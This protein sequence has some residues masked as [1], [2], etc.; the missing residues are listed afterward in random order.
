[1]ARRRFNGEGIIPTYALD[2]GGVVGK[3]IL[4]SNSFDVFGAQYIHPRTMLIGLKSAH[5]LSNIRDVISTANGGSVTNAGPDFASDIKVSATSAANSSARLESREWGR[6]Q[7]T[8]SAEVTIGV[9]LENVNNIAA[10]QTVEWGYFNSIDGMGFGVDS[11]GSYVF[12]KGDGTTQK[13]Y[14]TEWNVDKFDG[15]GF[16]R[17][18][19][20]L[21]KVKYYIIDYIW[22]GFMA[23]EFSVVAYDSETKGAKKFIIHRQNTSPTNTHINPNLPI[24]VYVNSGNSGA[25]TPDVL[26]SSRS[27]DIMGEYHP[28]ERH[29]KDIS[30]ISVSL[31]Q[32]TWTHL[33]SFKKKSSH[34]AIGVRFDGYEAVCA[35]GDVQVVV[36]VNTQLT[37]GSYGNLSRVDPMDT[38]L[39]VNKTATLTDNTL[40]TGDGNFIHSSLHTSGNVNNK[41]LGESVTS[42]YL[43]SDENITIIARGINSNATITLL[44]NFTEEW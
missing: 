29:S 34:K 15:T 36:L 4:D 16:S 30:P 18:T 17:Q 7:P 43:G 39:E 27:Y 26:M 37:G 1:M 28:H 33:I 40:A 2:I 21:T 5:G 44:A 42:S 41:V 22:A 13:F 23:I 14:Q 3:R 24:S 10:G 9:R 20:D 12:Y 11:T 6:Y 8:F 19:Y 31:N 32:T 35:L 25:A 38:A